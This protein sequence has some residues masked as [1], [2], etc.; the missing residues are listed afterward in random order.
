[1]CE[2]DLNVFMILTTHMQSLT[3]SNS[4]SETTAFFEKLYRQ[5]IFL[6]EREYVLCTVV[7]YIN[8]K[9]NFKTKSSS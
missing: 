8:N 1:M 5:K 6:N 7:H 3:N 2:V 9:Q 4:S